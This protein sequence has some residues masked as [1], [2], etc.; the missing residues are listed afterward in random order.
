MGRLDPHAHVQEPVDQVTAGL[1]GPES[2]GRGVILVR[3]ARAQ[4]SLSAQQVQH[5]AELQ[6]DLASVLGLLRHPLRP[7]LASWRMRYSRIHGNV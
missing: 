6:V 2:P 4:H 7:L 1:G 5:L 3:D